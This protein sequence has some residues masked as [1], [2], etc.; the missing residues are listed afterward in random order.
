MATTS[1]TELKTQNSKEIMSSVVHSGFFCLADIPKF[2]LRDVVLPRKDKVSTNFA[3]ALDAYNTFICW[4]GWE[5]TGPGDNHSS[6]GASQNPIPVVEICPHKIANSDDI[7]V[8]NVLA[9]FDNGHKV[10]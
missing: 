3:E 8:G 2:D 10:G 6:V 7:G 4:R 1:F 9:V 5:M